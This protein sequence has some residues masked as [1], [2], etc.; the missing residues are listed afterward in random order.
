M[1]AWLRGARRW[2]AV[3]LLACY[4]MARVGEL[5]KC[6]RRQLVLPD[7]LFATT[8][9]VFLSL[10]S[11]KTAARGRP[12]VQQIRVDDPAACRLIVLAFS[13]LGPDELLFPMSPAA[14]RTI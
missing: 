13:G 14:F 2:A 3:V 6:R 9:A 8:Q 10:E 12:K 11:S 4:G 7:D 1:A 5:L